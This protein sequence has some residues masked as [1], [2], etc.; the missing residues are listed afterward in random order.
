MRITK[1][2][3]SR[4]IG[5]AVSLAWLILL[6][7]AHA[8]APAVDVVNP[9]EGTI[10]TTFTITGSDFGA[11]EGLVFIDSR[12]CQ[13]LAWS[14][15]SIECRIKTPMPPREYDLVLR[16]KGRGTAVTLPE[17]FAIRPPRLGLPTARPHFVSPGDIVTVEGEFFGDGVGPQKVR[18]EDLQGNKRPCKIL[19]WAMDSITFE[20]P[21]G[22][23]GIFRLEVTNAVGTDVQPGW[24]T[25]AEP[26]D[27]PPNLVGSVRGGPETRNTATPVIFRNKLWF[28]WS[29]KDKDDNH[30][31]YQTWDGASTW[32][33][34]TDIV[35]NGE[36]QKSKTVISPVVVNDVLYV[37]YVGL[38]GYLDYVTYNPLIADATKR[39][40]GRFRV[41]SGSAEAKMSSDDAVS[42]RCAAVYNWVKNC[43]EV[44]YVEPTHTYIYMRTLNLDTG[45]WSGDTVVQINKDP[46]YPHLTAYVSAVFNQVDENDYVTY[47]SWADGYAG[48]LTELRDGKLLYQT[49][50]LWYWQPTDKN[51][52]P[53]LVDLGDDYIA[54]MYN[55]KGKQAYYEKY[56][57]SLHGV[58]EGYG[59]QYERYVPFTSEEDGGWAV[60][61]V[62]YSAK[63]ADSRSP[64][65]YRMDSNFYA[66]VENNPKFDEANWEFVKCEY[67]G[68]WMPTAEANYVD[69]NGGDLP[70]DQVKQ[71]LSDTF[72]L[73]PIL[74]VVDMPPYVENGHGECDDWTACGTEVE[75]SFEIANTDGLSGEYSAGPYVETG[76]KSRVVLD[77]SAGYAGGFDK[78]KTFTYTHS[79]TLEANPEGS[80]FAYYLVPAFNVYTLEWYDLNN[81][82]TETYTQSVELVGVT[83]RKEVFEPEIGPVMS[84]LSPPYLDPAVFL[85]HGSDDDQARLDSYS[86]NP[87]DDAHNFQ[88]IVDSTLSSSTWSTS[89]PGGFSWKIDSDHS[90]DNGFYCD[91]KIGA[92]IAKRIG[93][94]VEG[95]VEILVNTKTE[96]GVEAVTTLKNRG[97]SD[98]TDP[99]RVTEFH[100][101]GY[102]LK[103]DPRGYWVPENRK[104]MGDSPWF[105]TY[106]VTD[107]WP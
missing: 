88:T 8:G 15:E 64:T 31:Q 6:P 96:T 58:P 67:Y 72:D 37:F 16:P 7:L 73:W 104:G 42:G 39:W 63:V 56:S 21:D 48:A 71:R 53:T 103:P 66:V 75:L 82:P 59:T 80:I 13:V 87:T 47:L 40:Q 54:V 70:S 85:S 74:G 92:E 27:N 89:S 52:G 91:L 61:G 95:S 14:D 23:P 44:Y 18:I 2:G 4:L 94:G 78:S 99:A 50:R 55:R 60:E 9:S 105:I 93:F 5:T 107:W 81:T 62:V 20:L 32:S 86:L 101:N 98:K 33:G 45:T 43:I 51:S 76:K 49:T 69:F 102:W 57:K 29:D 28:F 19:D 24:G 77:I 46:S 25:F 12:P 30:V 90:I 1:K 41:T 17:A 26:P 65:G 97:P 83:I 10:G 100:V 11:K 35:V 34:E 3:M 106:Y 36:I 68:Y 22:I 79:D 38:G 84:T